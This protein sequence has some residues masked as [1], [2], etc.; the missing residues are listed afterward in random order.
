MAGEGVEG[1]STAC[2]IAADCRASAGLDAV[3]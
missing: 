1:H 3:L 2:A